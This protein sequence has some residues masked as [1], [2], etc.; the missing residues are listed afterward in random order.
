MFHPLLMPTL[1]FLLLMNTGYYFALIP[2]KAKA[3]I[4]GVVVTSTLVM[5]LISIGIMNLTSRGRLDL[6]DHR[7]R[8][9]PFLTTA[10]FYYIGYY[11]LSKMG[12]FPIY[13]IMLFGSVI[14]IAALLLISFKWKISAHLAGV[15]GLLG[16]MLALSLRLNI[17][18]SDLLCG[19]IFVAGL[20]GSARLVLAKHTPLQVWSGFLLGF[21]I[22][23][24]L[25]GFI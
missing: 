15:G 19:I 13:N 14:T 12:I 1:G 3:F 10:I 6:D 25:I 4:M 23:Y 5:P 16:A 21:L 22:N 11:A 2:F 20:V 17:N 7:N 24:L 8:M 18:S 9:F